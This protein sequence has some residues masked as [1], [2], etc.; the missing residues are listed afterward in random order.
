[1]GNLILLFETNTLF[2]KQLLQKVLMQCHFY[3]FLP[4]GTSKNKPRGDISVWTLGQELVADEFLP[5]PE[6]LADLK[7]RLCGELDK[8]L[9]K[10]I[11]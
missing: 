10:L 2:A 11:R 1:M 6:E 9:E 7:S 4:Q 5:A 8:L 3:H